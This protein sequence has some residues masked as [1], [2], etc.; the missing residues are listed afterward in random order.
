MISF[1]TWAGIPIGLV[2]RRDGPLLTACAVFPF[3]L[4]FQAAAESSALVGPPIPVRGPVLPFRAGPP[5]LS[6]SVSGAIRPP[7]EA[8]FPPFFNPAARDMFE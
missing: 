4:R 3:F 1:R 6:A 8:V 7:Y 5:K 2:D